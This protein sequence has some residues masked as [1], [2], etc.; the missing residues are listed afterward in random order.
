MATGIA[1][2]GCLRITSALLCAVVAAPGWAAHSVDAGL[3]LYRDGIGHSGEPVTAIVQGDVETSGSLMA[4]VGCHKRSGL[5]T[6]EGGARALAITAPALFQP[7]A[8]RRASL[9]RSRPAYTDESLARSIRDGIA[10]DGRILDPMMPRY[11]LDD[12][13]MRALIAYLRTLGADPAPGVGE[14]DIELVTIVSA[15]A[16]A[17][18]REAVTTV[19]QRFADIKNSGTRQEQRR[20]AASRRHEYGEKH[21]RAFRNWNLSVWTLEGPAASWSAQLD[22]LY[23]KKPPFALISGAT[24]GDS[25][26]VHAFC[27]RRE[28]PCILPVTD[29]PVE[30]DDDHYTI[31]YSAGVRLDA[32]VTARS[33]SEGYDDSEGRVLVAYVDDE[34]G[35]AALQAFM[36]A[37][38][39]ERSQRLV[40]RPIAPG[41][42][43]SFLDWKEIIHRERP[44]VLIAWLLPNQLQTLTSIASSTD[45]LP[46]RMYTAASFTDWQTI[47]ALPVF[48]Q[49]VLHVYPYSLATNGRSAFPREDAWLKSQ[50]LTGLERVPAAEALFACHATG[51]AM[52][53]MAD[54]YSREY[55][56]ETLEHMLDGTGMTTIFPVT[57]LGTS[58]RFLVKGAYV[59]RLAPENGGSR[60]IQAGW[61]QP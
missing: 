4:C 51:E 45:T 30:A 48:E 9:T 49:R 35:R 58:Q 24:G 8:E 29:L 2:T 41:T 27:E 12:E 15:N 60:Y 39:A 36:E 13:D 34:M 7:A 22:A 40:T 10:V 38:P 61:I 59:A 16:P 32:R 19:L 57:T 18:E 47:H 21:V 54:N 42:T 26:A 14:T 43:P 3:T 1:S 55:L 5:G 46:R 17:A 20:A 44:D 28:I 33:I 6:S 23:D 11:R 53:D 52:M 50:G 31:Y 37:W 25:S 56:I